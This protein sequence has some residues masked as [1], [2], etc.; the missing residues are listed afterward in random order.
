MSWQRSVLRAAVCAAAIILTAVK[1]PA[2]DWSYTL[3][4][5]IRLT[6]RANL[7]RREGGSYIGLTQ[8]QVRGYLRR[9]L[10]Q[11]SATP[12][13]E[14][15]VYLYEQ[16]LR[17]RASAGRVVDHSYPLTLVIDHATGV[18]ASLALPA[19]QKLPA[20]PSTLP[21][22]GDVW[23]A[24]ATFYV[25]P[26]APQQYTPVPALVQ[27]R[28]E[29]IEEYL[30]ESYHTIVATAATR[31]DRRASE[32][33]LPGD[34]SLLV[35]T[36]VHTLGIR[37]P[38][39]DGGSLLVRD[40]LDEQYRYDD[41]T[42]IRHTGHQL[43]FLDGISMPGEVDEIEAELR[44]QEVDVDQ[45]DEGLRLTVRNIHFEPDRAVIL[46]EE[47]PRL[48]Q[49]AQTLGR[50][51]GDVRFLVVGHTADVGTE[52]SQQLLSEQRAS[53]IATAL[54]SRGIASG[55]LITEGRA[56]REPVATN[57]TEEGRRQNRRVEI[58]VQP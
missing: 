35:V 9:S 50:L 7:S 26:T 49:I 20:L 8:S 17:D 38:L 10:A 2:Q 4:E 5:Q 54:S 45:T 3:P 19:I 48:D 51:P 13:Y 16:T 33:P 21:E 31:L 14:G 30:G 39:A 27:Y 29:G 34:L 56:G 43:V 57:E 44:D 47:R 53:A 6:Q 46:P 36:G 23:E 11:S 1:L 22:P 55:R 41:G 58:Y 52:E 37:I 12:R 28:Y 24:R 25:N 40:Q 32:E 18:L 15:R 42:I